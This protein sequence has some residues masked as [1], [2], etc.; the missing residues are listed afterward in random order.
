MLFDDVTGHERIIGILQR[1]VAAGRIAHA[2]LFSGPE[3]CGKRRTALS[4][5]KALY[6]RTGD[7]CGAC[8]GCTRVQALQHPDLH[9]LEP[10][11]AFIKIDQVRQLQRELTLRPYEAP[12]K[13]CI[14]EAVD[15]FN[16]ASGNA[17]LKT[18]EEPPGNALMILLTDNPDGVLTTIRSRCQAVNFGQLSED[19]VLQIVS[20][21]GIDPHVGRLAASLAG[22]SPGRALA[23][24]AEGVL[25]GRQELLEQILSRQDEGI[26]QLFTRS[27]RIAADKE[28]LA[29]KLDLLVSFLRDLLL[30][31][32]G[33][34]ELVN[35]DLEE[36]A[37]RAILNRSPERIMEMITQV[38]ETQRA[39]KRN[40]N[41]RLAMDVLLMRLAA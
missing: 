30:L 21:Q 16:P 41:A 7:A 35:S 15:R 3:G 31:H 28:T 12:F 27:E 5:V 40:V 37:R 13:C 36:T 26:G 24:C 19:A 39:L 6:C 25:N 2:Y 11:G 4:L 32:T 34:N 20:A 22:G 38:M 17:L 8:P 23:L 9:L 1:T 18:L 29:D 33:S 14:I 10:D